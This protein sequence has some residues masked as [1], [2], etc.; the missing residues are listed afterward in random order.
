MLIRPDIDQPCWLNGGG[1]YI[2]M[3]NFPLKNLLVNTL[4]EGNE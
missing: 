2:F 1:E 4:L 3:E